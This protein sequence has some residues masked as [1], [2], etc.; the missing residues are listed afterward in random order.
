[1]VR[2]LYMLI[3]VLCY[4]A[5]FMSFVYLIGFLAGHPAWPTHVDKGI[6][7]PAGWAAVVDLALVALFGVQHS[8]MAR[9]GFKAAW[10]RIVPAPLERSVYCLAAAAALLILYIFWHP[11]PE[12]VWSVTDPIGRAILWALFAA[13]I[14]IVFIATWLLNHFEL[15]GLAQAWSHFR[16]AAFPPTGFRTPL[17]YRVVRHPIYLGFLLALWATPHMSAG[18]ALLSAALTVYTLIG[19]RLEERDLLN[20]FGVRYEEYRVRVGMIIPRPGRR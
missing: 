12:V 11:I 7:A 20:R 10:T 14:G 19:I 8:V 6:A 2:A 9:P 5:F 13:G 17:F 15:F 4:F 1:M 16:G 18:H 3:A